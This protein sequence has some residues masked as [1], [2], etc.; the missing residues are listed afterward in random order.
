[1]LIISIDPNAVVS[2]M[3]GTHCKTVVV[4]VSYD[5]MLHVCEL[6]GDEVWREFFGEPNSSA[7]EV[8]RS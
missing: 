2:N 8:S 1:M 7:H 4:M 3:I 6:C 5:S